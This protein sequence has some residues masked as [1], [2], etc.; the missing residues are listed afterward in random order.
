M[1]G[2]LLHVGVAAT[3]PHAMGQM[4]IA[5]SNTRVLVSGQPVATVADLGTIAGCAF[6]VPPG[7]P[8]PCATVK[9]LAP[10]TRVMINGTPALLMPGPHLCQSADQIPA[11]PPVITVCQGRV[12]GT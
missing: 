11:G 5:S 7:K 12:V 6:T 3:C 9:W 10:A 4:S 1:P 2:P 8:Q